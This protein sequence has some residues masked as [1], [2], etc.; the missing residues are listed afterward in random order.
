MISRWVRHWVGIWYTFWQNRRLTKLPDYQEGADAIAWLHGFSLC[1]SPHLLRMY[2]GDRRLREIEMDLRSASAVKL[3]AWLD[4]FIDL[5]REGVVSDGESQ[6]YVPNTMLAELANVHRVNLD[7]YLVSNMGG[8]V[9][10]VEFLLVLQ[11]RL[12]QLN[13]ALI[14]YGG[15]R[16]GRY[17]QRKLA[18]VHQDLLYLL[19]GLLNATARE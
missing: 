4:A 7:T 6:K 19:R 13:N 8:R 10:P 15:G 3:I 2:A 17:Y 16:Y 9:D 5:V 18:I 14:V 11:G 1:V 12:Q